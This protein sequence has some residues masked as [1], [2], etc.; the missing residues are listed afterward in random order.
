MN[1]WPRPAAPPRPRRRAGRRGGHGPS[2]AAPP[3]PAARPPPAAM[4]GGGPAALAA[5][6][7][8][9]LAVLAGPGSGPGSAR[10]PPRS[11]GHLE[12]DVRWRR[13]FSATRFF[14][15]IDGGGCVEGT[16]WRERPGSEWGRDRGLWHRRDRAEG[17]AA[18]ARAGRRRPDG[19]GTPRCSAPGSARGSS[20]PAKPP[21]VL[22]PCEQSST[23]TGG[24]GPGT[25]CHFAHS[26]QRP[27]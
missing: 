20:R 10:R 9:A 1:G 6:L 16:R 3:C 23:A 24:V 7:A 25:R 2:P 17:T 13:L 8:G 4:R 12:G 21:A 19:G 26:A 15:R 14:L 18:G 27:G 22:L 5:C 11:Y